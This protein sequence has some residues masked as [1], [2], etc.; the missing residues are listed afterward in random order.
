VRFYLHPTFREPVADVRVQKGVASLD[1]VA[2][3]AFT[4]GAEIGA[5]R[6]ELDLASVG[7]TPI[8]FRTR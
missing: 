6:L 1:R 7:D 4:V 3:G 8:E 2:W 5:T